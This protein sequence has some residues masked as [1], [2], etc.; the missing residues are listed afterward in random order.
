MRK[1]KLRTRRTTLPT[2]EEVRE[3]ALTCHS[4][5]QVEL[6]EKL[7]LARSTWNKMLADNP[8]YER[9]YTD[10]KA[11]ALRS[12]IPREVGSRNQESEESIGRRLRKREKTLAEKAKEKLVAR[13]G[14]RLP[15]P[16]TR[17]EVASLD[18][19]LVI[20][21]IEEVQE[22]VSMADLALGAWPDTSGRLRT[23]KTGLSRV[24]TEIAAAR[25]AVDN[26][27]ASI[28]AQK[29]SN[30]NKAL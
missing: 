14:S 29:N 22:M 23:A 1:F 18:L 12:F 15:N 27:R 17:L 3:A 19:E 5:R 20:L 10:A 7:N 2:L 8:E 4:G 13:Y 9:V 30:K 25:V 16:V 26:C 6:L 21:A 28:S 11:Q 24:K